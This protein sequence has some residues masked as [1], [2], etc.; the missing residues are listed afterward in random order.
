MLL[1]FFLQ[2]HDAFGLSGFCFALFRERGNK[3]EI[4]SSRS[5]T[6]KSLGL[7]HG[8]LL[9]LAP[10]NGALLWPT[11]SGMNSH[12]SMTPAGKFLS[13]LFHKLFS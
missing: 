6:L 9:F 10:I 12:S 1:F 2:V 8:D 11:D 7:N 3:D 13:V 5:K 4:N